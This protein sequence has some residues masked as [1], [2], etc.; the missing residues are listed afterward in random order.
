[1]SKDTFGTPNAG[2]ATAEME[3]DI[4]WAAQQA[5]KF[6]FEDA[7]TVINRP[8]G[9]LPKEPEAEK[10]E[11]LAVSTDVNAASQH[12]ASLLQALQGNAEMAKIEWVAWA[13]EMRKKHGST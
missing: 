12:F 7:E 4:E 2:D 8:P 13:T 10:E 9:V 11:W 5:A 3:Q 1:V 6:Y